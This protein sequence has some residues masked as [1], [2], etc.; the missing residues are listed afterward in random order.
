MCTACSRNERHVVLGPGGEC[1]YNRRGEWWVRLSIDTEHMGRPEEALEVTPTMPFTHGLRSGL[2]AL[3]RSNKHFVLSSCQ[4]QEN[5][6]WFSRSAFPYFSRSAARWRRRRWRT[7]MCAAASG[8]TCNAA[9][10]AWAS[11]RGAGRRRPG[12]PR[13]RATRPRSGRPHPVAPFPNRV[14]WPRSKA[15][16][17]HLATLF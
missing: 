10:C 12:P 5:I 2:A 11:R 4:A 6:E 16:F 14:E 15:Q 1:C 13:C 8:W 17:L 9:F 3:W 7:S